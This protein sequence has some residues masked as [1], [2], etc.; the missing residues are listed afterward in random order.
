MSMTLGLI[1]VLPSSFHGLDP[2]SS[3]TGWMT[4]LGIL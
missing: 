1:I 2:T 3:L 4:V